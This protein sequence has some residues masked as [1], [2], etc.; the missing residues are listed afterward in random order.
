M[1]EPKHFEEFALPYIEVLKMVV[2]QKNEPPRER[3]ASS[4]KKLGKSETPLLI[5][6]LH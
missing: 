2:G 5:K 1:I 3:T 4:E 6:W